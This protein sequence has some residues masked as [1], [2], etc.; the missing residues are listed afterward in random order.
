MADEVLPDSLIFIIPF[1]D[2]DLALMTGLPPLLLIMV[3]FPLMI[4]GNYIT[5]QYL[6]SARFDFLT[7]TKTVC[8]VCVLR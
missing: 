4:R 8:E 1:R 5:I 3:F 7:P 6:D 2:S